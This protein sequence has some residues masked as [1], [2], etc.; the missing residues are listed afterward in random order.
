[1]EG[2]ENRKKERKKLIYKYTQE[3]AESSHF[4][5]QGK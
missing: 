3:D 1:M 4:E 5:R 2:K